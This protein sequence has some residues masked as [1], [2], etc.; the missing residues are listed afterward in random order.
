MVR[1]DNI[2]NRTETNTKEELQQLRRELLWK[3]ID[4][5]KNDDYIL[6]KISKDDTIDYLLNEWK[7][8]LKLKRIFRWILLSF[9]KSIKELKEYSKKLK[10]CDT[11]NELNG[12]ET[13]ILNWNSNNET[14]DNEMNRL[15]EQQNGK[16]HQINNFK[17]N[18]SLKYYMEYKQ[19]KLWAWVENLPNLVPFACAM[20]WYNKLKS[21]L[22]NPK[23]LSIVDFTK[24]K[25][26]KRFYLIDMETKTVIKNTTVGHWDWSWTKDFAET[27]S[28]GNGTHQSS[29]WFYR[30]PNNKEHPTNRDRSWLR[31]K[32]IEG[33]NDAAEWRWIFMH[34][35][36]L[37][38]QWCFTLPKWEAQN[39]INNV[40]WDSLLF[41]YARYS[42]YFNN[43]QYFQNDNW[44]ITIT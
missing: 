30:T 32:W 4:K 3:A 38:S 23:Y 17:I 8:K 7:G 37:I 43:S 28:N 6:S 11:I 13:E 42:N 39:I 12:L 35:W 41:A 21:E 14:Q 16:E 31:M 40:K 25:N 44:N 9:S 20:V 22:K 18:V 26:E 24:P 33:S 2:E 1:G 34:E 27:F 15:I 29:L 5:K 10:D 19:L 36:G